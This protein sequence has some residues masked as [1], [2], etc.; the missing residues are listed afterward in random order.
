MI[1]EIL[2][3]WS[4]IACVFSLLDLPQL[5]TGI[6]ASSGVYGMNG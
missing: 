5:R 3:L 1:E 6:W 4:F 2:F